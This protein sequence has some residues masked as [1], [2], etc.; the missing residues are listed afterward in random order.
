MELENQE[1]LVHSMLAHIGSIDSELRDTYIYGSFYEWILEKLA[2][3][4]FL[5][6][7]MGL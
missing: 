4:S 6:G 5:N 3:P 1:Q 7:V 2:R